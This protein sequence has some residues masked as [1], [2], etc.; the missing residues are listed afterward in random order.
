MYKISYTNFNQTGGVSSWNNIDLSKSRREI[1]NDLTN[2]YT[3]TPGTKH[4]KR[5]IINMYNEL[6]KWFKSNPEDAKIFKSF[7][8][9]SIDKDNKQIESNYDELIDN[10]NYIIQNRLLEPSG[11]IANHTGITASMSLNN[12]KIWR[13]IYIRAYLIPTLNLNRMYLNSIS[14]QKNENKLNDQQKE[15]VKAYVV[16]L[17]EVSKLNDNAIMTPQMMD[18]FN[19]S[20]FEVNPMGHDL[21]KTRP[22]QTFSESDLSLLLTIGGYKLKSNTGNP[23]YSRF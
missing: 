2:Q 7:K 14:Q 9:Q 6:E 13:K 10:F 21:M 19:K 15:Y 23:V 16:A 20:G 18:F 4:P 5:V 8:A 11:T 3:I 12:Q 22:S 17:S 1:V